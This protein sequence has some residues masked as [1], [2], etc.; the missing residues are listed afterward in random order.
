MQQMATIGITKLQNYYYHLLSIPWLWLLLVLHIAVL[1]FEQ[2]F[3]KVSQQLLIEKLWRTEA[4][5][6][7][8]KWI[9]NFL[10]NRYQ[11][12]VK[13]GVESEPVWAASSNL[14]GS[15]RL[16]VGFNFVFRLY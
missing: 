13:E 5:P 15:S 6:D 12:V 16:G 10:N 3:D 9:E 11:W 1:D 4:S 2:T 14:W 7:I 8:I